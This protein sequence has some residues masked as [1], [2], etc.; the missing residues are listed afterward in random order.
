MIRSLDRGEAQKALAKMLAKPPKDMRKSL[1]RWAGAH[2]VA[3]T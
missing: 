2:G 3:I 1:A